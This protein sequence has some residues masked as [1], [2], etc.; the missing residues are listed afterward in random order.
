MLQMRIRLSSSTNLTNASSNIV[1]LFKG[2]GDIKEFGNYRGIKLMSYSMKIWEKIIENGIRKKAYDRVPREVLKWVLMRQDVPKT[3]INLTQDMYDSSS[4]SVR[5]MSGVTEDFKV[6]VGVHQ[7]SV[8]SSYLFSVV[9]DENYKRDTTRGKGLRISKNKTE[10]IEYEFGGKDQ[11]VDVVRI[12]MAVG[13]GVTKEVESI[14]YLGSVVQ[15]DGC[16]GM[17][18]KHNI[19]CG[20]MKYERNFGPDGII[21]CDCCGKGCIEIKCPYSL[22]KD[23]NIRIWSSY[24][25]CYVERIQIDY[26]ICDEIVAKSKW[27]FYET[28]L[29]ELLERYFTNTESLSVKNSMEV[30]QNTDTAKEPYEYCTC[31]EDKGGKLI[32]C[33]Q[34]NCP[35]LWYHY[36]CSG[37][38]RK[39]TSNK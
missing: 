5:S 6:G 26:E 11:E 22:T 14:K 7:G 1:L 36:V 33:T 12:P 19:K 27:F 25:D 38:K 2:K 24:E 18:V 10:Y 15:K 20:W 4:I 29:P 31:K 39:P 16:F 23:K 13:G 3:Y 32:M 21:N 35:D 8:L 37:I 34:E 17:D 9:M 30:V 28:I